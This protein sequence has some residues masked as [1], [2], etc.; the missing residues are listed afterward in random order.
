MK[1][2]VYFCGKVLTILGPLETNSRLEDGRRGDRTKQCLR[3]H[4]H[5]LH[6]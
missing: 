4:L 2:V 5:M 6:S 1:Y 3:H